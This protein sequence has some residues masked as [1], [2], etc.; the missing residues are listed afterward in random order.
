MRRA[1]E[2]LVDEGVLERRHGSGTYLRR[3]DFSRSLSRF[4]RFRSS[5][6]TR[7]TQTTRVLGVRLDL[8]PRYAAEPLR[9]KEGDQAI[10]IDR[11][12]YHDDELFVAEDIW[13]LH[14]RFK[15]LLAMPPE[16]VGPMLYR[17]Y[18]T[19]CGQV[20]ARA[21]ESLRVFTA[22]AEMAAL[23][24]TDVG[25][26]TISIERVAYDLTDQPIEWRRSRGKADHFEY[27]IEIR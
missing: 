7:S 4:M 22:D 10:Y 26:P 11:R 21:V 20:I 16:E 14:D 24:S 23:L 18:E 9:L 27:R 6:S 3:S 12:R 17:T 19:H 1:I 13:L 8:I 5:H 2:E 25:S 15:P